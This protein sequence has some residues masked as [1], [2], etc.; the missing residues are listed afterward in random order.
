M[1]QFRGIVSISAIGSI[2]NTAV[3][4]SDAEDPD[5]ENNTS[6]EIVDVEALADMAVEKSASPDPVT[7][8]QEITFNLDISNLGPSDAQ[9][10]TLTDAILPNVMNAQYSTDGGATFNPWTGAINLGTFANG[11]LRQIIIRGIV[12]PSATGTIVNTAVVNSPTPDPNPEN[13]SSTTVTP[14]IESADL[15]VIKVQSPDPL[16]PGQLGTYTITVE[17]LGP[18]S[19]QNVVLTDA[20]PPQISGAEYSTDSVNFF[21]WTGSLNLGTLAAGEVQIV[22]IR[23]LVSANPGAITNTAIVSSTTPDPNPDNNTSTAISPNEETADI[24]VVKSA[25]PNPVTAGDILTYTLIVSN[26]GPDEAQNVMLTD[27]IPGD[28]TDVEYSVDNGATFNP[29]SGSYPIGT[30]SVG[31]SKR[32]IIRGTVSRTASGI[33]RNTAV[34]DSTTFDPDTD[35]NTSTVT[36]DIA[37]FCG[38][39]CQAI[40]DLIESVALEEAGLAHIMNAEGEKL[41][42]I[43]GLADV[44][45]CT[46]LQANRSVKSM[47]DSVTLLEVVL[48]SKIGMF[49]NCL[50]NNAEIDLEDCEDII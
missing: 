26:A 21:P 36:T 20:I 45:T 18:S 41:Q 12:S 19:A 28:L 33:I 40:T 47:L 17:N 43:I 49:D 42:K 30:L 48:K 14:V 37:A 23:G 32:I 5:P 38:P 4:S 34:V 6:T 2:A 46:L 1:I 3:V 7:A 22:L 10:V 44:P 16:I 15:A 25:S 27:A 13:N 11:E 9:S 50:C 24:S 29:W 39:R 31:E 35:N 8:G